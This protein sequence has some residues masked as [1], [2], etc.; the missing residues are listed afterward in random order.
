MVT[1]ERIIPRPE[2]KKKK[3]KPVI[4]KW[5]NIPFLRSQSVNAAVNDIYESSLSMGFIKVNLIGASSSGKSTLAEVLCHQ[6]HEIDPTF[7]VHFL[8]DSDLINFRETIQNLSKNNQILAFDDLSGLVAKFGKTALERLEAQITTIRHI[9]QNEDRRIIMLLNFHAQ[10]KLSKFLRISNFTFYT[11][12][13]NEEINYLEELLGKNQKSKILQFVKLRSQSR[14]YHKFSFQ[15]S[16]GNHFTYKDGDPFRILL[17][18][19]SI[20]TR[21]IVSPQLSW[22]LDGKVC[23]KCHPSEKTQET[24][25]NLENFRNDFSKKFGKGIAKRAI[26]LKLLRHGWYT[27]P[28]RVQQA[29]KY[30]EQFF[31]ARKIN[32]E[33][34]AELYGLKERKTS[35]FPDKQPMII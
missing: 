32:L 28:K 9:N 23:Q 10:K 1:T 15:L 4:I 35:L 31:A 3:N 5:K 34:L 33:E 30:I 6:L 18:N 16:R 27:Q 12:C 2:S 25:I 21:F 20:S 11:D 29:E 26:E 22:I 8:Q 24:K 17:Y 19:N 14:M 7:E 13:Q